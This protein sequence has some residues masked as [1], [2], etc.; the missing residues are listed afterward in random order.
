[1]NIKIAIP[2]HNRVCISTLSLLT[3]FEKEN[4]F[5]FVNDKEQYKKYKEYG[6]EQV[7]ITNTIGIQKARNYILDYFKFGE[8]ILQL[9]DDIESIEKLSFS[10]MKKVLVPMDNK[11]IKQFIYRGFQLAEKNKT[12][13]W[14]LYP[15]ENPFYMS[16]KLSN[17]GFVIGSFSGIIV[18]ELRMDDNLPLKEDYDYTMQHILKYKK[19]VR[20][21]NITMKIKHYTNSGGCVDSRKEDSSLEKKCHD[22]LLAKYPKYIKSNPTR[23]NEVLIN[24]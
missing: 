10:G 12:G 2:S 15:V 7:I 4:I 21:D 24:L 6:H 14:G 8:K 20:F 22:Y 5:I 13:L 3:E 16:N 19:I 23:E 17:K 9:D 1:M 18:D 11:E